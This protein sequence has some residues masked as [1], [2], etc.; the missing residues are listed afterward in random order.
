MTKTI[1]PVCGMSV[2]IE[3]PPA[4]TKYHDRLYYFCDQVCKDAFEQNP[5]HYAASYPGLRAVDD[6][7][8]E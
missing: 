7:E 6:A 2:D 4:Q 5:E 1:D 3:N 8:I